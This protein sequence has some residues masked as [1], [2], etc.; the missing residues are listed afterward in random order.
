MKYGG[1]VIKIADA[2]G[3]VVHGI[4]ARLRA[5]KERKKLADQRRS[6]DDESA[7]ARSVVYSKKIEAYKR[8]IKHAQLMRQAEE[9]EARKYVEFTEGASSKKKEGVP[10]GLNS[11]RG[12]GGGGGG[13]GGEQPRATQAMNPRV[14]DFASPH[15]QAK[16]PSA[17]YGDRDGMIDDYDT[18]TA[19]WTVRGDDS[20]DDA[21]RQNAVNKEFERRAQKRQDWDDAAARF[22]LRYSGA[23]HFR[24]QDTAPPEDGSLNKFSSAS[25]NHLS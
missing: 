18:E 7:R 22:H 17:K 25:S 13:G 5:R 16:A 3:A 24:E 15:Q 1:G 8:T 10:A 6:P 2:L 11:G 4:K 9:E 23:I 12:G 21:S 14:L 19:T 20:T